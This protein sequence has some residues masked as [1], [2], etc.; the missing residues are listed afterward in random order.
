MG[1]VGAMWLDSTKVISTSVQA[2]SLPE[3][4][5]LAGIAEVKAAEQKI[6]S[7]FTRWYTMSGN[8]DLSARAQGVLN[9]S[10]QMVT[11]LNDIS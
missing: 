7:E 3:T 8:H 5:D 4:V 6:Q 9:L 2:E 10:H 1:Q 11:V